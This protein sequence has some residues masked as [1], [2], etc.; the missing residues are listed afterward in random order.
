[1]AQNTQLIIKQRSPM[2]TWMIRLSYVGVIAIAGFAA[3][4]VGEHRSGFNNSELKDEIQSMQEQVSSVMQEN[5]TLRGQAALKDR[6]RQVEKHA[7]QEVDNNLKDL[8]QEILELKEEVAFYRGI[9]S[10]KETAKGVNIQSLKLDK[11]EKESVYNFKL[12]LT[13]VIKNG[14]LV[15]GKAKVLVEGI[16]GGKSRQMSLTDISGGSIQKMSLRF[17]YFQTFEGNIILP[18]GFLPS[19]VLV[20]IKPSTK[21]LTQVKKSFDWVDLVS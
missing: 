10:P 1:M 19:R 3:Y 4:Q 7:Y 11:T 16:Q 2:K 18:A 20:E 9:V 14:R 17:K 5:S 15:K 8:Q 13:Q 12:V 21:G 6:S